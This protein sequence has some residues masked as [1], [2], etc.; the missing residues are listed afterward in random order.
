[1][2]PLESGVLSD[3]GYICYDGVHSMIPRALQ[4]RHGISTGLAS[5]FE[6]MWPHV[7]T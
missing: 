7:A 5:S 2:L 3:K 1:M 4:Q 6:F